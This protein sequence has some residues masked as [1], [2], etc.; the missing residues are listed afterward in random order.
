MNIYR[1]ALFGHRDFCPTKETEEK[2]HS[3]LLNLIQTKSY[4]EI[5]IGRNGEF[6]VFAASVVKLCGIS[7]AD[8]IHTLSGQLARQSS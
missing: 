6:D 1:V 5:Y 7:D 3:I 2:L 4:L 8:S